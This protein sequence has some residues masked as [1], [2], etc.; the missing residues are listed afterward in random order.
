MI[1]QIFEATD[2]TGKTPTIWLTSKG[3]TDGLNCV[4]GM[5]SPPIRCLLPVAQ[6][7]KGY[8]YFYSGIT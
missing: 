6:S 8:S 3:N 2:I 7:S 5:A 4:T 1:G